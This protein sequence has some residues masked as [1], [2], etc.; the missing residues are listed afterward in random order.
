MNRKQIMEKRAGLVPRVNKKCGKQALDYDYCLNGLDPNNGKDNLMTMTPARNSNKDNGNDRLINEILTNKMDSQIEKRVDA[1]LTKKTM[2]PARNSN[3]DN[4]MDELKTKNS[5]SKMD[6]Q[7]EKRVD[8]ELTLKIKTPARNCNM[9]NGK[10]ELKTENLK[11]NM[12]SQI[13]KRVDAPRTDK[14]QT[15]AR[16]LEVGL[17]PKFRPRKDVRDFKREDDMTLCQKQSLPQV[18]ST[19]VQPNVW[20]TVLPKPRRGKKKAPVVEE[21]VRFVPKGR[22]F[23]EWQTAVLAE[24]KKEEEKKIKQWDDETTRLDDEEFARKNGKCTYCIN[25]VPG[26]P[27]KGCCSGRTS[28]KHT[29]RERAPI[30][31]IV[32]NAEGEG[33]PCERHS[34]FIAGCKRCKKPA[35]ITTPKIK[36]GPMLVQAGDIVEFPLTPDTPLDAE[37]LTHEVEENKMENQIEKRVDAIVVEAHSGNDSEWIVNIPDT[38]W[39]VPPLEVEEVVT[40][41]ENQIETRVDAEEKYE[42]TRRV[43]KNGFTRAQ[44]EKRCKKIQRNAWHFDT[45]Y[46]FLPRAH[47]KMIPKQKICTWD[48][49]VYAPLPG[50]WRVFNCYDCGCSEAVLNHW[51]TVYGNMSS[52]NDG[53]YF[54]ENGVSW[55]RP[56][57]CWSENQYLDWAIQEAVATLP[58]PQKCVVGSRVGGMCS[59]EAGESGFCAVHQRLKKRKDVE[60]HGLVDYLNECLKKITQGNRIGVDCNMN[61]NHTHNIGGVNHTHNVTVDIPALEALTRALNQA[62]SSRGMTALDWLSVAKEFSF[63]VAHV[64][65]AG[66]TNASIVTSFLHFLSNLK[67]TSDL[68]CQLVDFVMKYFSTET[69]DAHADVGLNALTGLLTLAGV[70]TSVLAVGK[71]P[72]GKET[73]EFINRISR[74]DASIR[75][76]TTVHK[77]VKDAVDYMVDYIRVNVFGYDSRLIDEW[78]AMNKWCDAVA[79]LHTTDFARKLAE[80][81]KVKPRLDELMTDAHKFLRMLDTLKV[82]SSERSRFNACFMRLNA[83]VSEANGVEPGSH[84]AR[85]PPQLLQ[86][87]GETG[88]GK[89]MMLSMLNAQILATLGYT[90]PSVVDKLVYYRDESSDFFDGYKNETQIVVVDDFGM[91]KDTENNPSKVGAEAIRMGNW[92]PW[93][94]PMAHLFEKGSTYFNA[95]L[96]IWTSN[97]TNV[98]FPSMS[99]PH[100]VNRRVT[101]KYRVTPAPGLGK[102]VRMG[103]DEVITLNNAEVQKRLAAAATEE[104]K[105]KVMESLWVFQ[106]LDCTATDDTNAAIPVGAPMAFPEFARRVSDKVVG[107]QESGNERLDLMKSYFKAQVDAHSG[108]AE[109]GLTEKELEEKELAAIRKEEEKRKAEEKAEAERVAK[110]TA[111]AA[112]IEKERS[113]AAPPAPSWWERLFGEDRDERPIGK[114]RLAKQ[115]HKGKSIFEQEPQEDFAQ[116]MAR[117]Q[118]LTAEFY[119]MQGRFHDHQYGSARFV[120]LTQIDGPE[121]VKF[122]VD[123]SN[124]ATFGPLPERVAPWYSWRRYFYSRPDRH[125]CPRALMYMGDQVH[126][127]DKKAPV[128]DWWTFMFNAKCL[129]LSEEHAEIFA[130]AYVTAIIEAEKVAEGNQR[131]AR[132]NV[133]MSELLDGN[134]NMRVCV[135]CVSAGVQRTAYTVQ[136]KMKKMLFSDDG[137]P[138]WA[139]AALLTAIGVGAYTLVKWLVSYLMGVSQRVLWRIFPSLDPQRKEKLDM[140]SSLEESL[141]FASPEMVGYKKSLRSRI[142][143]LKKDLNMDPGEMPEVEAYEVV[144]GKMC[145]FTKKVGTDIVRCCLMESCECKKCNIHC[146]CPGAESHQEATR[147]A[148]VVSVHSAR[149]EV[150]GVIDVNA[151]QMEKKVWANQWALFGGETQIGTITFIRGRLALT[152]RHIAVLMRERDDLSIRRGAENISFKFSDLAVFE[153][154]SDIYKHRD[155]CMLEFPRGVPQAKDITKHFATQ[156]DLGSRKTVPSCAMVRLDESLVPHVYYTGPARFEDR[157]LDVKMGA[158]S[159]VVRDFITYNL[160]SVKGYCGGMVIAYDKSLER[161]LC[162]IHMAGVAG[163]SEA[164]ATVVHAGM[165]DEFMKMLPTCA[166]AALPSDIPNEL[167]ETEEEL[168]GFDVLGRMDVSATSSGITS[169]RPSLLHGHFGKPI[170]MPAKLRPFTYE[171]ELKDPLE[172]ARKKAKTPNYVLDETRLEECAEHYRQ[173]LFSDVLEEDQKVLTWEEAISGKENDPYYQPLK[174]QTS[175][176]FGWSK[177]GKGKQPWLGSE[178]YVYDNA[179]LVE[180]RDKML[181]NLREGKRTGTIWT[182]TL[183]DERRPIEKVLAGKTRLFSAGEMTYTILF[184]QYFMGFCAHVMRNRVKVESCVGMNV[185]SQDWSVVA[186]ALKK[187][188]EPIVAGDFSNYDG[189]LAASILWKVLDLIEEFYENA[190]EEEKSFRRLMWLDIVHSV[191]ATT[192]ADGKALIYMWTHS[193]PSGCPATVIIN[194]IYHS[195]A[196]RYVYKLCAEKYAPEMANLANWDKNVS[197][198]NYGDDDVYNISP[199][200]VEWFNQLTMAEMFEK[201]G[202]TYTDEAKTGTLCKY[203]KLEDVAFLKRKFVYMPELSAWAS[204]LDLSVILE[205]SMWVKSSKNIPELTSETLGDAVMELGQHGEEIYNAYRPKFVEAAAIVAKSGG[206]R[207]HVPL[208][209]EIKRDHVIRMMT[210]AHSGLEPT[211]GGEG[212]QQQEEIVTFVDDG[213]VDVETAHNEAPPS[214]YVQQNH[215]IVTSDVLGFLK[216][217][218]HIADFTWQADYADARRIFTLDLPTVWLKT[219]MIKEKLKGFRFLRGNLM[220]RVSINA[221]PANAGYAMLVFEPVYNQLA[222]TPSSSVS[223]QGL[224]G[225]PRATIDV[226][227][228]TAIEFEIPF[229]NLISHYDMVNGYGYC[230]R[231]VMYVYSALTG[232][233]DV[234]GT[235]FMWMKDPEIALPT[236]VSLVEAHGGQDKKAKH[237]KMTT[238]EKKKGTVETIADTVGEISSA[239]EGVPVIG[240]VAK[241]VSWVSG[242]ASTVASWFGWSKP[243]DLDR[244]QKVVAS[245]ADTFANSDGDSKAKSLT[246][247][248]KNETEIPMSLF[249]SKEDEMAFN[250]ILKK[251]TFMSRFHMKKED[252]QGTLLWKWPVDPRACHRIRHEDKTK[253]PYIPGYVVDENSLLSYVSSLARYY[254]GSIRYNFHFVKSPLHSARIRVS[255]VPG[256]TMQTPFSEID[257]NKNHSVVY[258]LRDTSEFDLDVPYKWPTPWKRC[259]AEFGTII[260]Q[261]DLITPNVPTAMIYVS[262]VNALRNPVIAKDEIECIIEVSAGEDFQLAYPRVTSGMLLVPSA[263]ALRAD[264]PAVEAHSG[265]FNKIAIGE[266]F[267]GFRQVLKRYAEFPYVEKNEGVTTL[268]VYD[269]QL[270]VGTS[271][272][273]PSMYDFAEALFRFKSGSLRLAEIGT[274]AAYYTITPHDDKEASFRTGPWVV[275]TALELVHEV[276]VPFY[277]ETIGLLTNLGSPL[278][279][280]AEEKDAVYSRVPS[281]RGTVLMRHG[282]ES[283]RASTFWRSIGEDFSFG[284]CLGAPQT[285]TPIGVGP[286]PPKVQCSSD[287][288]SYWNTA[289][290]SLRS[291]ISRAYVQE[292]LTHFNATNHA[293]LVHIFGNTIP[294]TVVA[295][296]DRLNLR[297]TAWM[298]AKGSLDAGRVIVQDYWQLISNELPII[299]T[300]QESRAGHKSA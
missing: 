217:P 236:G 193:Q 281:N 262:V 89:S 123:N 129:V 39:N 90:D 243:T 276:Q 36:K 250:V 86:I 21:P 198:V 116:H 231:V 256:A 12:D 189:T 148:K 112:R 251:Q 202:M 159:F 44:F 200:I 108:G 94:L 101:M 1:K 110:E 59:R 170:S 139:N 138:G 177:S 16:K 67:L 132:F 50:D 194:S 286:P 103:K 197:H 261:A 168:P 227:N 34:A 142:W 8:A 219:T 201:I 229:N 263:E 24:A 99:Y 15:P 124:N 240:E 120:E 172:L 226:A 267:T 118:P 83:M 96:V 35:I 228:Q 69:V 164:Y 268:S 14:K 178:D 42:D 18:C 111:E 238:P 151:K 233:Q 33:T 61:H 179:E 237:V 289:Q 299:C 211:D 57:S 53:D 77:Y 76:V 63:M 205:M 100:A 260:D 131:V 140:L 5:T 80:D 225:Y 290:V 146:V 68:S 105:I 88:T 274:A 280:S 161:K 248:Q 167:L 196:A 242:A 31:K 41:M 214:L 40:T 143:M 66:G 288:V 209:S 241:T 4:G 183:K 48:E 266:K 235:V 147:G 246:L 114:R 87:V 7:I 106:E 215:D 283:E 252:K 157:E 30:S 264:W 282:E 74:L 291:A 97:K 3:K 265:E 232:Q 64:V 133:V 20:K 277:Q 187:F 107:A 247:L 91:I 295:I 218:I 29:R 285:L 10:D 81:V 245:Y 150:E 279:S 269:S 181:K 38:P 173:I 141:M 239:F 9:N 244:P 125:Y 174:R 135:K 270:N 85:V 212:S 117:I 137:L 92:A 82:S 190:T 72:G 153:L 152:N 292:T 255:V 98:E 102:T 182:D 188:G 160:E 26:P 60:F 95:K 52:V 296:V 165:I 220:I 144:A 300:V 249:C 113:E 13:E 257:L 71:M 78:R 27:V 11:F 115:L 136:E 65:Q 6:S 45:P 154:Q 223:L 287:Y 158:T 56:H 119:T 134:Y 55:W 222:S 121:I 104:E 293:L 93:Q 22:V 176:G 43:L 199:R 166:D 254:R 25:R 192:G 19:F 253:T 145:S 271:K 272:D 210:E 51:T 122:E 224:S 216:R 17:T 73:T 230:G 23:N 169:I 208:Y 275:K 175:A 70:V 62:R 156:F 221:Q 28:T 54:D 47:E 278:D 204:P 184:R 127:P 186:R 58:T 46:S 109:G 84:K 49:V 294:P 130:D 273:E 32:E 75:S 37:P 206:T 180:A 213:D 284:F 171:G 128:Y 234:D 162:G 203:R 126:V 163:M 185:Y 297:L 155:V 298:E 191:H 258:D 207:V 79:E 149:V 259:D 2:T 195:L